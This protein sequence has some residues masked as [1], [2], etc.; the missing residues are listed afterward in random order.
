MERETPGQRLKP[1]SGKH[2]SLGLPYLVCPYG[3]GNVNSLFSNQ[4]ERCNG[5][6]RFMCGSCYRDLPSVTSI[7]G[8]AIRIKISTHLVKW[9][10]AINQNSR[11]LGITD[12]QTFCLECVAADQKAREKRCKEIKQKVMTSVSPDRWKY[13][14]SR[15]SSYRLAPWCH[16]IKVSARLA[17]CP[18][19]DGTLFSCRRGELTVYSIHNPR[20]HKNSHEY[21]SGR[22]VPRYT[23]ERYSR[24]LRWD[25]DLSPRVVGLNPQ[26]WEDDHNEEEQAHP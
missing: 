11:P 16:Q 13:V 8:N 2:S 21:Q 4:C 15:Q 17:D 1:R 26:G 14:S 6:I 7:V 20:L 19:S 23:E 24:I 25:P 10:G 9:K 22:R 5:P 3:C 12:E 18:D